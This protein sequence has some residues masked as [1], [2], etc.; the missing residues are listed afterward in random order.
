MYV[1]LFIIQHNRD[2]LRKIALH[3][4]NIDIDILTLTYY[5]QY[6]YYKYNDYACVLENP[7]MVIL[8]YLK[9]VQTVCSTCSIGGGMQPPILIH[10]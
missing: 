10:Q 4:S 3:K 7:I 5:Y 2:A 8:V 9:I 1:T 6:Y